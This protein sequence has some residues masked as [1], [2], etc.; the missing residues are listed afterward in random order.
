MYITHDGM[1]GAAGLFA[2]EK[3]VRKMTRYLIGG[4]IAGLVGALAMAAYTMTNELLS[5]HS[6]FTP[7]YM[8]GAPLV[9]MGAMERGMSGGTFQF[10]LVPAV[11]GMVA[12]FMWAAFWGL[13]FGALVGSLRVAGWPAFSLGIL[14]GYVAGTVMSAVVLPAVGM[15]PMWQQPGLQVFVLDHLAFGIPLALWGLLWLP[16]TLGKPLAARQPSDARKH[17]A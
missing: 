7:L 12:H 6:I 1:E 4:A 14:W 10:E 11:V 9:G 3:G 16:T 17:V 8:T 13:L 5:G 15:K 2:R